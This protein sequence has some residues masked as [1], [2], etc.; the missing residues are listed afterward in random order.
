MAFITGG[1]YALQIRIFCFQPTFNNHVISKNAV[2]AYWNMESICFRWLYINKKIYAI[3]IVSTWLI[4]NFPTGSCMLVP[5]IFST[6][7]SR[8]LCEI[9]LLLQIMTNTC[10]HPAIIMTSFWWYQ[11]TFYQYLDHICYSASRT[12]FTIWALWVTLCRLDYNTT[13]PL[14]L[15]NGIIR[16]VCIQHQHRYTV[17]AVFNDHL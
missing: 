10:I 6:A 11:R 16:T 13:S 9:D 15:C 14:H 3:T 7:M 1:K 8:S 5:N 4:V 12:A 2:T 17:I